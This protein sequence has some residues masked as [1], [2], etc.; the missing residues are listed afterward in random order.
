MPRRGASATPA[1][2][3]GAAHGARRSV[4][5]ESRLSHGEARAEV[6]WHTVRDCC[7]KAGAAG[8]TRPGLGWGV[9]RL[10]WRVVGRALE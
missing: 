3:Q 9:G 1:A 4:A 5:P 10:G 7:V 2:A 8:R 6:S